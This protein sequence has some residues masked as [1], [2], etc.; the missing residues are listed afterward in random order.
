MEISSKKVYDILTEKGITQLHHANSVIT[1]C[2]FLREGSLISRGTVDRNG[3]F[4]TP[5]E[6]DSIDKNL[7]LWFDVF[8]DT[9]DIHDRAKRKNVYGP[10]LFVLDV[11]IIKKAYTGCVWVTRLNPTKWK[12]KKHEA[13]WFTSADD[14][15]DNFVFGEFDQ[16]IVFRHSGGELPFGRYLKEVVVDDPKMKKPGMIDFYSMAYGALTLA[17]TEGEV[18]VKIKKRR[19][20]TDCKCVPGY[21]REPKR[22]IKM[23]FPKL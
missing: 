12:S 10:V 17:K 1:A 23:F 20:P 3:W 14:L 16:M 11:A 21:K 22:T 13:R 18:D 19:C 15:A 2:Q 6:S 9:V 4:Q 8:V 5:Q 7:S